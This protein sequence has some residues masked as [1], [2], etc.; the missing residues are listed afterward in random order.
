VSGNAD[1]V[2]SVAMLKAQKEDLLD[3][4]YVALPFVE[5]AELDDGY[6][7]ASVTRA[8][9]FIRHTIAKAEASK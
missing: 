5:D 9:N 4:L 2:M 6:K 3:A 7:K 1:L 8:L